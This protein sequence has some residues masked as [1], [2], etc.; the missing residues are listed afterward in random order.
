MRE[1]MKNYIE[2]G[3]GYPVRGTR[4]LAE[5]MLANEILAPYEEKP[6]VTVFG[7]ARLP[8]DHSSYEEN[9]KLGALLARAGYGV[10]T[11]GAAGVMEAANRGA[12]EVAKEKGEDP[13][14][15]SIG[16][17]ITLPHEQSFNPYV[18][19]AVDFHYF[20]IRKYF[21]V[22]RSKA[23][24][25]GEGG[26]GTRD[27]LWEVAC[28]IQTGKMPL[29]PL[30]LLGGRDIWNG[31]IEDMRIMSERGVI[32][33]SDMDLI[34]VA[35]SASEAV[36]FVTSFYRKL[37]SISYD[38]HRGVIGFSM[39]EAVSADRLVEINRHRPDGFPPLVSEK[40]NVLAMPR[41][42][43]GSYS[44]LYP[45]IRVLNGD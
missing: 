5:F 6:Y 7:S 20:F 34:Y 2:F 39:K 18:G 8:S 25:L 41:I 15:Y 16:C 43:F 22:F 38:K 23:F 29:A 42:R 9:R 32:S 26:F 44:E 40:E 37:D 4:I 19:V 17:G 28:L 13:A 11:G 35:P 31:L 33:P 36:S 21:L 45:L 27:E 24:I 10:V 12:W 1:H 30:I 3:T 14:H